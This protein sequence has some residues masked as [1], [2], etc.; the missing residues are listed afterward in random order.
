[1][2]S[3]G[4]GGFHSVVVTVLGV[5]VSISIALS[6]DVAS[7]ARVMNMANLPSSG[8]Q[9]KDSSILISGGASSIFGSNLAT[10]NQHSA[11]MRIGKTACAASL[12]K[13]D[14]SI[15]GRSTTGYGV[16]LPVI[17]TLGIQKGCTSQMITYNDPCLS[18]VSSPNAGA[19]EFHSLTMSGLHFGLSSLS[20]AVRIYFSAAE[21]SIWISESSIVARIAQG[22]S[23]HHHNPMLLSIQSVAFCTTTGIFSYDAPKILDMWDPVPSNTLATDVTLSGQSFGLAAY[24]LLASVGT[25]GC[26][27]TDWISD[28]SLRCKLNKGVVAG[29]VTLAA[30]VDGELCRMCGQGQI[31][32]GCSRT[33]P[34]FC[35]PC[36]SCPR[37]FSR[38]CF[39][40]LTSSGMCKPC[41]NEGQ[42]LGNRY[43]KEVEG[44]AQTACSLCVVCGGS[45]Q[46][47]SQ[48][49]LNRCTRQVDTECQ[50]CPACAAG[51]IRVGCAGVF[52]GYCAKIDGVSRIQSTASGLLVAEQISETEYLTKQPIRIELSGNFIGNSVTVAAET[53]IDF[54]EGPMN[55]SV[56]A[57]IPSQSMIE[58]QKNEALVKKLANPKNGSKWTMMMVSS[59]LYLSPSGIKFAP[60]A[61]I[62]F[63]VAVNADQRPWAVYRWNDKDSTWTET[64][65]NASLNSGIVM[66][67]STGFSSY[68]VMAPTLVVSD[69]PDST[70]FVTKDMLIIFIVFP[71]LLLICLAICM[72]MFW[73]RDVVFQAPPPMQKSLKKEL[74][75]SNVL[76]LLPGLNEHDASV[77]SGN[78]MEALV[79]LEALESHKAETGDWLRFVLKTPMG[80]VDLESNGTQGTTQYLTPARPGRP[81][82]RPEV[83]SPH[84]ANFAALSNFVLISTAGNI[85]LTT[86]EFSDV[87]H[88][89]GKEVR[90]V[91]LTPL[92][93]P[94]GKVADDVSSSAHQE[95]P[96][97]LQ[98]TIRTG[99]FD[100]QVS[101]SSS[102]PM[103]TDRNSN[104]EDRLDKFDSADSEDIDS[105]YRQGGPEDSFAI[106]KKAPVNVQSPVASHNAPDLGSPVPRRPKT[107]QR[108]VPAQNKEKISSSQ[109]GRSRKHTRD[110]SVPESMWQTSGA[111][112]RD[113]PRETPQH[114]APHYNTLQHTATHL[115]ARQAVNISEP[116]G[117]RAPLF[118]AD[119]GEVDVDERIGLYMRSSPSRI[120]ASPDLSVPLLSPHRQ[121]TGVLSLRASA[122]RHLTPASKVRAIRGTPKLLKPHVNIDTPAAKRAKE[123]ERALE[124]LS[125]AFADA[126]SQVQDE[127]ARARDTA[128]NLVKTQHT[129]ELGQTVNHT[130]YTVYTNSQ[131]SSL[132][133]PGYEDGNDDESWQEQE[134][135]D[136]A[137]LYHASLY[138]P[139]AGANTNRNPVMGA[140][141][142]IH[143]QPTALAPRGVR[144][145][146]S[147]P[148]DVSMPSTPPSRKVPRSPPKKRSPVLEMRVQVEHQ[149]GQAA[150]RWA[151][152]SLSEM[153]RMPADQPS[154][155]A[156]ASLRS[157]PPPLT[158]GRAVSAAS[159]ATHVQLPAE[160]TMRFMLPGHYSHR[161]LPA[162]H[163]PR[164]I[165]PPPRFKSPAH[166]SQSRG[167]PRWMTTP[168]TA[169]VRASFRERRGHIRDIDTHI[170]EPRYRLASRPRQTQQQS[171]RDASRRQSTSTGKISSKSA[172][173]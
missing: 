153:S 42:D 103:V 56:S 127:Q 94:R 64:T 154:S 13:S 122:P 138:H 117:G 43:F 98:A 84:P 7:V 147:M 44:E 132:S 121:Y 107:Q 41:P 70:V 106:H 52:Q 8:G 77:R 86:S 37:G 33:N 133:S 51:H 3:G 167:D 73:K 35:M 88:A 159:A 92:K 134:A 34:G 30:I 156:S 104:F 161:H 39:Q 108:T 48:Y 100:T 119:T 75:R 91:F 95:S 150:S 139:L 96:A 102:R 83:D 115:P 1:M 66:Y 63:R 27:A 55:I 93:R 5:K 15:E 149:A 14:S 169:T 54:P 114:T 85:E 2:A 29:D 136:H 171:D 99:A 32:V 38:D 142:A 129:E 16:E 26:S 128:L 58:A 124:L 68:A 168:D 47:G 158:P 135:D 123:M 90:T 23:G 61:T 137:S 140:L 89:D 82:V 130:V 62:F 172:S 87:K 80:N 50:D 155:R 74:E 112:D 76:E 11:Q 81:L 113:K 18:T 20:Q 72:W 126:Q 10:A 131:D 145:D 143:Q 170:R 19:G 157:L 9:D 163:S 111:K 67:N 25:Y 36:S 4:A 49:E 12:W 120:R 60:D 151:Q 125:S 22:F 101:T 6:Y 173:Y 116:R 45:N 28:T 146:V 144:E 31:L 166:R 118:A 164:S 97:T 141:A 79:R 57:L 152:A 78:P 53:L 160:Q 59:I 65:G 162:S 17:V 24:S 71:S 110:L 105:D 40:G 109:S 148:L 46:N 165:S 69:K 21:A